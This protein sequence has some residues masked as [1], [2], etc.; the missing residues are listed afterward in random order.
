METLNKHFHHSSIH[1]AGPLPL[2]GG[3]ADS[4]GVDSGEFDGKE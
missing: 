1:G 4:E 3:R 2:L